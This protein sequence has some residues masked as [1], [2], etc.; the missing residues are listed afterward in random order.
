MNTN[1]PKTVILRYVTPNANPITNQLCHKSVMLVSPMYP[2]SVVNARLFSM[3][4]QQSVPSGFHQAYQHKVSG[5][6]L[7]KAIKTKNPTM[8][9]RGI[10]SIYSSLR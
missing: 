3:F 4:T 1:I 9:E 2:Y 8:A 7:Q 10:F 5:Q 6:T